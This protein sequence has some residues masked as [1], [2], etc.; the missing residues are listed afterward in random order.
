LV[1][2]GVAVFFEEGQNAAVFVDNGVG[3]IFGGGATKV[4]YLGADQIPALTWWGFF[5]CRR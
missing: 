3:F 4:N 5:V 1:L 2:D